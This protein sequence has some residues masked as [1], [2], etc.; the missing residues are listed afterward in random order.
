MDTREI[1]IKM[2]GIPE[3]DVNGSAIR[4]PFRQADALIYYLAVNGS[5]TKT[6]LCDIL[7]GTKCTEETPKQICTT[8]FI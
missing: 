4:L 1:W 2:M 3:I 7:W 5:A 6:K 8:P